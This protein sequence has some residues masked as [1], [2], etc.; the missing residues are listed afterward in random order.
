MIRYSIRMEDILSETTFYSNSVER[1][2]SQIEKYKDHRRSQKLSSAEDIHHSRYR[3]KNG[4][5]LIREVKE[6]RDIR[7][8]R[9]Y[10]DRAS[11]I[12]A[13]RSDANH[14][15]K[16]LTLGIIQNIP[17]NEM[18]TNFLCRCNKETHVKSE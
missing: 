10:K 6:R 16:K 2:Q 1:K 7:D 14:I 15:G 9:E 4:R 5:D 11:K 13:S 12:I 18:T 3:D 8:F 17:N